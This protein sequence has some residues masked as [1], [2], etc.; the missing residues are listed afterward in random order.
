MGKLGLSLIV[1]EQ[2]IE[3]PLVLSGL[4]KQDM[5][6]LDFS[7]FESLLP[8]QL[9]ALGF[10]VCA[11]D[12][13][14][15]PFVHPNLTVSITDLFEPDFNFETQFDVIIAILTIEHLGIGAYGDN[16]ADED[17]N[18]RGVELLWSWLKACGRPVASVP[19]GRRAVFGTFRVYVSLAIE[20]VFPRLDANSTLHERRKGR[21]MARS[22]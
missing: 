12:Q 18:A 15:H 11:L 8:L 17:A 9:S 5:H 21:D 16:L 3:N 22:W 20:R 2:I 4:R 7:G 10:Q 1:S 19:K 6:F 13:R 14:P